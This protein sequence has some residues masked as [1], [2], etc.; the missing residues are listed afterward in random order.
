MFKNRNSGLCLDIPNGSKA[1]GVQLDQYACH[2]SYRQQQFSIKKNSDG[3]FTL[4]NRNS[5]LCVQI[6]NASTSAGAAVEQSTCN[7]T[8]AQKFT[9]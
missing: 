1:L 7:G 9:F 6:R 5:G 2:S 8:A 3:S 4:V